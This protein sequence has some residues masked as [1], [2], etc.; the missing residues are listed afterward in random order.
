MT[1]IDHHFSP[2][3]LVR[4][5]PIGKHKGDPLP[6]LL[7][8]LVEHTAPATILHTA[9]RP[10]CSALFQGRRHVIMLRIDG[11][12]ADSR[13]ARFANGLA[14]AEW[15]LPGHFVADISI[16]EVARGDEAIIVTLSALTIEEW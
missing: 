7:V 12:D 15:T 14:C 8:Q 10:W 4:N 16:D 1:S 5:K 9:S 3:N 13:Q 11:V 2:N 6:R